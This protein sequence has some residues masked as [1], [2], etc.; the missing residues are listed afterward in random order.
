MF[1]CEVRGLGTPEVNSSCSGLWSPSVLL[2]PR[3]EITVRNRG[4]AT[5]ALPDHFDQTQ[6]VMPPCLWHPEKS[7]AFA[8]KGLGWEE[9]EQT[10][11]C[12]VW[13]ASK[14]PG[15]HLEQHIV[16]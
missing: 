4:F 7:D 1:L 3:E 9:T 16:T 2:R 5:K 8:L 6:G 13:V 14:C 11:T 10:M 12:L 15:I